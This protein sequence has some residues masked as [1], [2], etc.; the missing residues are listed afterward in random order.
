MMKDWKSKKLG[1]IAYLAGRIGWKGLTAK[2][3][4]QQGPLFLSVHALNYGDYIDF[5]DA[6]HISQARYDESPE[7][8]LQTNDILICKDGAGIGKV[9]IVGEL[10]G[11]ATINSSLLL[12]RATDGVLP[13][14]LYYALCSPLFQSLVQDRIDG[15]TT[16]H[17]YQRE[18]RQLEIPLPALVE[19]KRIVE[20]LDEA[21]EGIA[22]AKANAE[23]NVE[24]SQALF[25]GELNSIFARRGGGWIERRLEEIGTTQTGST[26][27]TAERDNYGEFIPFVKPADFNADGSLN[28]GR[29]GLSKKGLLQARK[30]SA[31]SVL[32]VCI[33]ATIGKCGYCERD[34]TTNQQINA[35][36]PKSGI[37]PRFL[38]YQM[39]T[40]AFQRRV[41]QGS[42][43][44]TLPIINKSK[45]SELAVW[46][47]PTA[48]EQNKISDKLDALSTETR[49]LKACY[50]R[51]M[52]ELDALR[53]SALHEA[54]SG[55]L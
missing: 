51:K 38:Y 34:I 33:G 35:L 47:P 2:E 20:I 19:Q 25:E 24:N 10:P 23:R 4:T 8:M 1:D 44:A 15:A 13:K 52:Q 43:R 11:P 46:L 55:R 7:I 45:W 29:D 27:K 14:Y 21:F 5:R 18:I 37:H 9:G 16:P 42:G 50:Y 32:M 26:P 12:I 6:F 28:Y 41:I 30:V 36:T 49:R 54:F 17:L 53:K 48:A 39:G 22:V 3:Y 40:E 31:G